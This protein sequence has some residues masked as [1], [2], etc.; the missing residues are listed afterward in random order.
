MVRSGYVQKINSSFFRITN[1]FGASYHHEGDAWVKISTVWVFQKTS[2][3]TTEDYIPC[4]VLFF[5]FFKDSSISITS[6][7]IPK[8]MV[9]VLLSQCENVLFG[10]FT[11]WRQPLSTTALNLECWVKEVYFRMHEYI[12]ILHGHFWQQ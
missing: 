3:S 8:R 6:F 4:S 10:I 12:R 9:P 7:E 11:G 5:F 1:T 2:P